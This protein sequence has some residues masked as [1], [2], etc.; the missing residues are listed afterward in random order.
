MKK[1]A[2]WIIG[3]V[4]AVL[5]AHAQPSS[6]WLPMPDVSKPVSL[7]V[8]YIH[9]PRFEPLPAERLGRVMALTASHVKEHL[10]VSVSFVP[11]VEV[12]IIKVFA[13]LPP[14]LAAIA[15]SQ[16]L[17]A[18]INDFALD[19]L[20][21]GLL[22]DLTRE[23]DLAAQKSFAARYLVSPPKDASDLAFARALVT[24]QLTLLGA[25]Q[26]QKGADGQPLI[27]KDRYNEYAYW[28]LLGATPL[29]YEVIVTNQ[30]V[31]SA[32]WEG[33]SVH[34]AVRGG[35]SNGIT[36][37]NRQ[38]RY[39]L[40]SMLSTYPFLDDSAQTVALRGGDTPTPAEAD[41]YMALLLAHELGHQ[42]LHLGHPFGNTRCLMTPPPLL[43]FKEW[44]QGLSARD[45]PVGRRGVAS[46]RE[47]TPGFVKF[48]TPQE[49]YK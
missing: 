30:L 38:G 5:T 46:N 7:R 28:D 44:A 4:A 45:C 3:I 48:A 16:R 15:E 8:A 36:T 20:A 6:K 43:R 35:V 37:Q 39:Q 18:A 27:G 29:P 40:F 47:N 31:A 22:K 32:E 34:S 21:R 49:I 17:D 12:P 25:W 9:N 14:R 42:L 33:N 10:G 1:T 2:A 24:T 26:A 11:P 19:R 41:N 23:G 13:A